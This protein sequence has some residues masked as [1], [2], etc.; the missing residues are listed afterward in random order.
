MFY[1]SGAMNELEGKAS[2]SISD[3]RLGYIGTKGKVKISK[4]IWF[5]SLHECV[6]RVFPLLMSQVEDAVVR[7][8]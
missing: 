4:A 3:V 1:M 5:D 6:A 2:S 7:I 8:H